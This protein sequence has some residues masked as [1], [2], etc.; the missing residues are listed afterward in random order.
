M[1]FGLTNSPATFQQM[2]N[3]ILHDL[4]QGEKVIVYLDNI[5]IFTKDLKEHREIVK[6]VLEQLQKHHLYLKIEKCTFEAEQVEYLR[7]IIRKGMVKMDP[8]KIKAVK[9]WPIPKTKKQLQAFLGF[10]NFYWQFIKN[11][12]R[13][14]LILYRLCGNTS[15]KWKN[16]HTA[17]FELIKGKMTST[18]VL[19]LPRDQGKWLVETDTSNFAF[20]GIL[21]QE[22]PTGK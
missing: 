6:Q 11:F 16:K 1:F 20:G 4:I 12:S 8:A 14:C 10:C 17:V 2:M 7:V 3:T 15:W 5:L 9:N 18:P 13:I 21:A 19:A 22:Q